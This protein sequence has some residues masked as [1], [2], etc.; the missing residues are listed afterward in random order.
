[1]NATMTQTPLTPTEC[2]QAG[3]TGGVAAG[4]AAALH[5]VSAAELAPGRFVA[6]PADQLPDGSQTLADNLSVREGIGYLAVPGERPAPDPRQLLELGRRLAAV[7]L[8]VTRRLLDEAVL[9]LSERSAGGE[10]LVRKQLVVGTIADA[11]AQIELLRE[12]TRTVTGGTSLADLHDRI[13][14]L[15]WQV[16]GLFG[17]AGYIADHPARALYVSELVAGSWIA[18]EALR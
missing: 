8:G 14:E 1:M 3:R 16:A 6:V 7:R 4:L 17:A 18:R 11:A 5:G 9:H 13:S 10:A 12:Y 15:D 2:E